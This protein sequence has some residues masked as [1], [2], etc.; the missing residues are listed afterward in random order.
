LLSL[1]VEEEFKDTFKEVKSRVIST[2]V[3]FQTFGNYL[4]KPDTIGI[5]FILFIFSN[6]LFEVFLNFHLSFHDNKKVL[7]PPLILHQEDELDRTQM[8]GACRVGN[9]YLWSLGAG[10]RENRVAGSGKLYLLVY[11]LD[12]TAKWESLKSAEVQNVH[13]RPTEPP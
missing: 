8:A 12:P 9:T 6:L 1:K 5:I 2:F 4:A 3:V 13:N 10:V 11:E 7:C